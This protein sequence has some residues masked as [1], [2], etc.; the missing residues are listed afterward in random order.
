MSKR[1]GQFVISWLEAGG[2]RYLRSAQ[3]YLHQQLQYHVGATNILRCYDEAD[4]YWQYVQAVLDNFFTSAQRAELCNELINADI[5]KG[6][7]DFRPFL[8][9]ARA[10]LQ[11]Q[12]L[13]ATIDVIAD[14]K[15][16]LRSVG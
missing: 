13:F 3:P 11:S 12:M 2:E 15:A 5:F 10:E 8:I 9:E 4:N 6:R 1:H 16:S 7:E 14:T